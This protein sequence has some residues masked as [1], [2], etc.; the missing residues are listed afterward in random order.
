MT[1][2][3]KNLMKH[4]S[5]LIFSTSFLQNISHSK[6]KFNEIFSSMYLALPAKYPLFLS[7][8]KENLIFS[9]YFQKKYLISNFTKIS[10]IEAKLFYADGRTYKR[11]EANSRLSQF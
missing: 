5:V 2:F 1:R 6:K 8:F 10:S 7:H 3:S 11:D 4:K 9:L